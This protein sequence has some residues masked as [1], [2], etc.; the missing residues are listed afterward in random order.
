MNKGESVEISSQVNKGHG[1]N[2]AGMLAAGTFTGLIKNIDSFTR[3]SAFI[4][5]ISGVLLIGL[6]FNFLWTTL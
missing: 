3:V 5:K 4:Q 2:H 1:F 6:G